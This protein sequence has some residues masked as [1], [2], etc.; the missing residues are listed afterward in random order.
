MSQVFL[1]LAGC[2]HIYIFLMESVFWGTPRVNRIFGVSGERALQNRLFALNQGFYNLFLAI[3]VLSGMVLNFEGW[4][5]VGTTLMVYSS[6][7]MIGAALVL[8]CSERKLFRAAVIQG[9]PPLVGLLILL[10]R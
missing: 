9:L 4:H 5:D 1:T 3:A 8:F 7:S 2:I 10:L 6:A